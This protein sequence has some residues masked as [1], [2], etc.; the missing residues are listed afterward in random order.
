MSAILETPAG[1]VPPRLA[2]AEPDLSYVDEVLERHGGEPEAVLPVLQA[3]QDHYGYLPQSALEKVWRSSKIP[4]A[5][6]SGVASFYDMFRHKPAG[7]H[8]IR[9]CRG[10]ACHVSGAERVEDALR[11]QL[12]IAVGQDTDPAGQ[13]TVEQVACLGCCTLAPVVRIEKS[14]FG[15]ATVERAHAILREFEERKRNGMTHRST[16]E[17]RQG[18]A[19]KAEIRIGLGSCCIA[20]GSDQL[21]HALEDAVARGRA[22]VS[23]KRVGCVGMCHR[24]PLVEVGGGAGPRNLYA[25]LNASEA[26]A[27]VNRHFRPKSLV[28][29]ARNAAMT[30]LDTLLA[31]DPDD[32]IGRAAIQPQEP[33]LRGFLD[34]QVHIATE[35]FGESDPL[36]LDEYI[37]HGGFRALERCLGGPGPL[38]SFSSGLAPLSP[39]EIPGV[40]EESGLRG[41][42]GAGFSTGSK[43]RMA[44]AQVS[45]EKYVI[46]NGD[47]GDPGAFMDRMLLE[48]FPFRIIEGMAI[49][50]V[51]VGAREGVFYIRHEYPLALQRVRAAIKLCERRGWMGERLMGRDYKFHLTIKQGGG[52][53]VCGEETALIESIEGR[54]GMPK[55]RPP[56][57]AHSGLWG[58]PTIINNVETL[59][60]VPWI[61]RNGAESFASYGT[62]LS[63]GTKVFALA[64]NVARGGLIEVPMGITIREIVERIGGGVQPGRTF[65]AVQIGGPS[66]GCIPASL[67][68]TPVDFESLREVGAIMGSGG[69]VVLDDTACM[70][71]IARY[72]LQ[73]TQQQSCGKCTFCR[74]GT[75]RML[76]ILD[77]ICSGKG[78]PKDLA[79]LETLSKQVGAGSLCGLGKTAPNP[80]LTTLRYFRHE[81]EAHIRG[82]CPAARCPALIRY[83]VLDTCTGCTICAQHC[84]VDAI[85]LTP[86]QRHWI[87]MEKCIRCDSCR[88]VCPH[89]AVEKK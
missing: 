67:A 32:A 56:F 33:T 19:A 78:H 26:Q 43:W 38:S 87:D 60:M 20:K 29:R 30:L 49:A 65:K 69:L 51:A 61:L 84:P 5:R 88:V 8:L 11:R 77:R 55:L 36:D 79:N 21:Y 59:A 47:E 24:T 9:V 80:V 3:L 46:C 63:K 22:D 75:R 23:V 57:P 35:H 62:V 76:E 64:G 14:T 28:R 48:S 81:Y 34:S 39:P 89:N 42:G 6:I 58:K 73:F 15:H 16:E 4:P 50:A 68:D 27:L 31:D 83:R 37:R 7:R 17:L 54:R 18:G 1:I 45:S 12:G 71:D 41:R 85:P 86:Y 74:I 44:Q 53:F 25:G 70:V 82:E 13:F 66:G 72:F 40:I 10:T 52:A 2:P